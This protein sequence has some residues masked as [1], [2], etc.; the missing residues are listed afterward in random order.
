MPQVLREAV[1]ISKNEDPI[2][3][4]PELCTGLFLTVKADFTT[5]ICLLEKAQGLWS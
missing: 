1:Y 3:S 4:V 2:R 5:S